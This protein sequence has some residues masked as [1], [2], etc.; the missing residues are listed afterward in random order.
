M[1]QLTKSQESLSTDVQYQITLYPKPA[2]STI[3]G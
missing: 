2:I 3:T 1:E